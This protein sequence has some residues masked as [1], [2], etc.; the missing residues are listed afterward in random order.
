MTLPSTDEKLS[1]ALTRLLTGQPTRTNGE[2]TVTNLCL[3]AGVG[4]DSFYRSPIKDHFAACRANADTNEPETT[5]LREEIRQLT[6][7]RKA[8]RADHSRTLRELEEL[9]RSYANQIQALAL[10]NHHLA[11]ENTRLLRQLDNPPN[12]VRTLHRGP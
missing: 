7:T 1:Q 3:E 8:E 4:R 11:A 5:R 10:D 6:A 9:L 2:L 12:G